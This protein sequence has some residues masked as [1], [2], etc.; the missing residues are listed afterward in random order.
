MFGAWKSHCVTETCTYIKCTHAALVM[1]HPHLPRPP[2]QVRYPLEQKDKKI[3]K[4]INEL[5]SIIKAVK[6]IQFGEHSVIQFIKWFS[7]LVVTRNPAIYF[8]ADLCVLV[9]LVDSSGLCNDHA[10]ICYDVPTEFTQMSS[11]LTWKPHMTCF[12]KTGPYDLNMT[13]SIQCLT[14]R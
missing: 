5:V 7:F 12:S 1:L 11:T 2:L 6:I 8:S 4:R 14:Y 13:W 10:M 9:I 3:T